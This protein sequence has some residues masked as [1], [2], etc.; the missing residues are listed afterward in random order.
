MGKMFNNPVIRN[1]KHEALVLQDWKVSDKTGIFHNSVT[2]TD[3]QL[4]IR[5][6]KFMVDVPNFNFQLSPISENKF[7]PVSS[8]IALE[9]EFEQSESSDRWIMNIYAKGIKRATFEA[10]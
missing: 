3:W 6:D 2:G 10:C 8:E 1:S 7:I 5:D 4:S 9:F